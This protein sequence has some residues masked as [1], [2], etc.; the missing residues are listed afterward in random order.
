MHAWNVKCES[1]FDVLNNSS[2]SKNQVVGQL[3]KKNKN[4]PKNQLTQVV[5][6]SPNQIFGQLT[7]VF[8]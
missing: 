5:T 7:Q 3:T 8:G 4:S 6:N 2:K 1:I